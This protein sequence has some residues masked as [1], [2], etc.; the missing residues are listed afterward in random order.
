ML[1]TGS[2]PSGILPLLVLLLVYTIN[3]A[4]IALVAVRTFWSASEIQISGNEDGR[5]YYD[6]YIV[7]WFSIDNQRK[8]AAERQDRLAGVR[9]KAGPDHTTDRLSA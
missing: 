6:F 7:E 1:R 9:Q 4:R 2:F 5:V 8:I 3:S